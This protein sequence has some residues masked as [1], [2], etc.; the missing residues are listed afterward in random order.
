MTQKQLEERLEK[1][2]GRFETFVADVI[3]HGGGLPFDYYAWLFDKSESP[4]QKGAKE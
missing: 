3:R 1:L 2:E 4:P